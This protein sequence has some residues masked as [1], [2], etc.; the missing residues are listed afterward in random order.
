MQRR[1]RL[2]GQVIDKQHGRVIAQE[3]AAGLAVHR[4]QTTS[5]IKQ[6]VIAQPLPGHLGDQ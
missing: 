1:D 3:P 4:P 2:P 6:A 5:Q